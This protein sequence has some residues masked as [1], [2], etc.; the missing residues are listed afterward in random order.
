M[1]VM[2]DGLLQQESLGL[3]VFFR[4]RDEFL[5]ELRVDFRTV[6]DRRPVSHGAPLDSILN[7]LLWSQ[8]AE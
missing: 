3:S 5:I 7:P 6:V 4:D 2:L 1:N 8:A